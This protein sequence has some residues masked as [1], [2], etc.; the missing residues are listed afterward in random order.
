MN[1]SGIANTIITLILALLAFGCATADRGADYVSEIGKTEYDQDYFSRLISEEEYQTA[2]LSYYSLYPRGTEGKDWELLAS[3]ITRGLEDNFHDALINNDY[4]KALSLYRSLERTGSGE[5]LGEGKDDLYGRYLDYLMEQGFAG[6]AGALFLEKKDQILLDRGRFTELEAYFLQ[7]RLYSPLET[8]LAMGPGQTGT[9]ESQAYLQEKRSKRDMLQGTVTIWVNRGIRL[10]KG[11]GLPDRVIGSGF[12]IDPHGYILT[13]YHVISSEVD[14]TYEGY[15]KL[16][17]K[18]YE[19][20]SERIPATVVGYDPVLDLAL[21]KAEITSPYHFTFAP[22]DSYDL[23]DS[24]F[25]IGSPGGLSNTVTSGTISNTG[26]ALQPMGESLQI[27]VPINPGNSG[28]PLLNQNGEIIGV[29]FAGVEEYEGVNFAIPASYVKKI[30]PRLYEPG[31][32]TYGWMGLVL[33]RE[34]NRVM[35][36]YTVPGS[37]AELSQIAEGDRITGIN[38]EPVNRIEELQERMF[39]TVP[40]E[41]IN[42]TVMRDGEELILPVG[43]EIRPEYPIQTLLNRD[44][45]DNL[46]APLFG[47]KTVRI[48]RNQSFRQYRVEEVFPGSIADEAGF[49][50]GDSFT[51]NR[52]LNQEEDQVLLIQI[53]IKARKSGF[54]ES[55]LQLGVWYGLN[56]FL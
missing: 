16:Y 23:G 52:W 8:L 35:V 15:S 19:N 13:N 26:R 18:L 12:F 46:F 24:I 43:T 7:N 37:P 36:R 29:V 33:Y 22:E 10:E 48:N 5:N 38:G 39:S 55:G 2:Y 56:S 47:M 45:L 9:T 32:V 42:L 27:D 20:E 14:P 17:I 40:G 1:R 34:F 6:A 54:M 30:L 41:L 49:V 50:T 4:G 51:L 44:S 28:G 25:A 3:R 31:K 21:L 53:V 11:V